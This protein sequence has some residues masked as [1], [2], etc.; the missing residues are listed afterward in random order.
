MSQPPK[1]VLLSDEPDQRLA[2]PHALYAATHLTRTGTPAK[3][4]PTTVK[5]TRQ[6]CQHEEEWKPFT[7]GATSLPLLRQ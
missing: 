6:I 7:P 1:Q 4:D 3:L 2:N 5:P